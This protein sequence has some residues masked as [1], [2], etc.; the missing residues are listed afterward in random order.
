MQME[1]SNTLEALY[2]VGHRLLEHDRPREA[3][4]VFRTML[5]VEPSDERGWLA[6]GTCHTS[7]DEPAKA[8]AIFQLAEDACEVAVRCTIARARLLRSLGAH[9][10]AFEAYEGAAERA[11]L[12]GDDE[13]ETLALTER[14][15]S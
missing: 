14:G 1:Q 5:L 15:A 6:L 12:C 11:R 2:S 8:L 3:I 13:L 4:S 9:D 10:E 7:L